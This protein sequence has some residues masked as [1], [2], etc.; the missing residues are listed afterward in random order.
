MQLESKIKKL[1]YYLEHQPLT[2]ITNLRRHRP[3]Y[4]LVI[5]TSLLLVVGLVI[6]YAISPGLAASNGVSQSYY[7]LRQLMAIGIGVIGFI[8]V[9]FLPINF[10]IKHLK[11]LVIISA[12]AALAVE[13]L[14]QKV[15]GA[16]RWIQVGGISFQ[17]V[18]LIKFTLMIWLAC[19][20]A[21]KIRE[22]NIS[23]F[24]YTLKP[25][26]VVLLILGIVVAGLESDLGSYVVLVII[27]I[28]M[29]FVAGLPFRR[30][31]LI[32]G[33][34]TIGVV[35]AISSSGYRRA[36]LLTFLH[37]T[38]NCQSSATGYQE[39][40]AIIAV[41]SGG[42]IGKGLG[43][44]VQDFGYLPETNN[45]SIFAVYA[46]QFGFVGVSALII[47]FLA[48]FKRFIN[49]IEKAPDNFS[50]LFVAGVLAWVGSQTLINIGAMTGLLPL[51]GITL[52]LISYGGT[53]I[54]FL[55]VSIGLVFNISHY[56]VGRSSESAGKENIRGLNENNTLR[57]RNRR[58]Y[59]ANSSRSE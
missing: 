44:G 51:K 10:W 21:Q 56:T 35:L 18:E 8:T 55:M 3:D 15:N 37:P 46:E 31:A 6:I 34:I 13:V 20:L 57:G 59:Y 26:L 1:N 32:G 23:V 17:A 19:F 45:D 50:R 16:V 47:L 49:I 40:Q 53:S 11:I 39:C 4:M 52:P 43:K 33:I 36:R 28:C 54:V 7:V 12:I 30:I 9:A 5:L 42:I 2:N 41:G 38:Q 58:P 22:G 24:K 27:S 25:L 14:G 29:A 48:F